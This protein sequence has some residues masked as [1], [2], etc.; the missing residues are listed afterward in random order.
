MGETMTEE[1][2][3][4]RSRAVAVATQLYVLEIS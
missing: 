3:N 4:G 2:Q 1:G